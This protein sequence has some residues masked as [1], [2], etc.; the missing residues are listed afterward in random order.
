MKTSTCKPL[1]PKTNEIKKS[2][3]LTSWPSTLQERKYLYEKYAAHRGRLSY[4]YLDLM[5]RG[6]DIFK[7]ISK[8]ALKRAYV[9]AN[10]LGNEKNEGFITR[11]LFPYFL[12]FLHYFSEIWM[13]F[14]RMDDERKNKLNKDNF[15][16]TRSE[17]DKNMSKIKAEQLFN[18][19]DKD[20]TGSVSFDEFC[21]WAIEQETFLGVNN[22][23]F[24]E[25]NHQQFEESIEE[26]KDYPEL[27]K[28][29]LNNEMLKSGINS[30]NNMEDLDQL[31]LRIHNLELENQILKKRIE[32][33][34][35]FKIVKTLSTELFQNETEN[36]D[37]F[38]SE[39]PKTG[40][41]FENQEKEDEKQKYLNESAGIKDGCDITQEGYRKLQDDLKLISEKLILAEQKIESLSKEKE[42]YEDL[43]NKIRDFYDEFSEEMGKQ[44]LNLKDN[45]KLRTS[46][47]EVLTR[48][49][50]EA[51]EKQRAF[52]ELESLKCYQSFLQTSLQK[53][54]E[55]E[56]NAFQ[57]EK[58]KDDLMKKNE[59]ITE[60]SKILYEK[61]IIHQK[62]SSKS[63]IEQKSFS[64][65]NKTFINELKIKLDYLLNSIETA[66]IMNS[67]WMEAR[68]EDLFKESGEILE[69]RLHAVSEK[70]QFT[71][72]SIQNLLNRQEK[73]KIES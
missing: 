61:L 30:N 24:F 57:M 65:N 59:K 18:I 15:V 41:N 48:Y 63:E 19:I 64:I 1:T 38:F 45:F 6:E 28:E 14:D 67:N 3:K 55:N 60:E 69:M 58:L 51:G 33:Q 29:E 4:Q 9:K 68:K 34:D 73:E 23:L 39:V 37:G 49:K 46:T 56:K 12:K 42:S 36:Y 70:L 53:M 2:S 72:E 22:K 47:I 7:G 50:E 66:K 26:S 5:M 32:E 43:I 8:Q 44:F 71:Q 31:R 11:K 40:E 13:V 16:R 20:R 35:S 25:M 27:K 62:E 10:T 54:K 17:I 21:N 52:A